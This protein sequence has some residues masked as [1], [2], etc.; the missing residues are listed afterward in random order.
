MNIFLIKKIFLDKYNEFKK[1][2]EEFYKNILSE[3]I[4]IIL[5]KDRKIIE[6]NDNLKK[7]NKENEENKIDEIHLSL[8]SAFVEIQI[9]L[10]KSNF[11]NDLLKE[12]IKNLTDLL[13]ERDQE[14]EESLKNYSRES[15]VRI[16][17]RYKEF[18]HFINKCNSDL[19]SEEQLE[20]IKV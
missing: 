1:K 19:S 3:T 18:V 17:E 15:I 13:H 8:S 4:E 20:K 10:K 5:E 7:L 6:M 14:Y 2:N 12:R 11:E 16:D 9:E